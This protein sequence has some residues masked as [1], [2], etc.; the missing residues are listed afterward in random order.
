MN[1]TMPVLDFFRSQHAPRCKP[2]SIEDYELQISHFAKYLDASG[3]SPSR[4]CSTPLLTDL[5]TPNIAACTNW[6]LSRGRSRGT[7]DKLRRCLTAVANTAAQFKLIPRPD[8]VDKLQSRRHEPTAWS[9]TEFG[10]ILTAAAKLTGRVGPFDM[11]TWFAALLRVAYN[12][13]ARVTT[14]MSL[15][16]DWLDIPSATLVIP[17]IV[18]KDDEGATVKLLPSTLD[19][20]QLLRSEEERIF[21]HWPYDTCGRQFRALNRVLRKCIVLAGLRG[22][23]AQVTSRD[24]WHKL[25]RT[26]ATAI[27]A[28]SRDIE[29]VREMLGHSSIQITLRYID[30]S[31]IG[32]KL[33][34]DFL[35]EPGGRP[36]QMRLWDDT[37]SE[38]RTGTR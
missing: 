14:L 18:Q 21:G 11:S 23:M 4:P 32:R 19:A 13:G 2:S 35:P 31:K 26:F 30:K 1:N 16:W 12:S 9:V 38:L 34:A 7:A 17:P 20:L 3:C 15:R 33:Q 37:D 22:S 27:Y 28:E 29:M 8:K 24:L 36:K 25:R 5:T 6:Q 10:Q